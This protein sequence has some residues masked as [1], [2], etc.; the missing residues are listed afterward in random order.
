MLSLWRKQ[1]ERQHISTGEQIT[2]RSHIFSCHDD[3][4]ERL[5]T[6]RPR[7]HVLLW[8][9]RTHL[10][11]YT[12]WLVD[13][14]SHMHTN[15]SVTTSFSSVWASQRNGKNGSC[16]SFGICLSCFRYL[17]S[18]GNSLSVCCTAETAQ[19]KQSWPLFT[20]K[21]C[22]PHSTNICSVC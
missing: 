3:V 10:Q 13:S 4:N 11:L 8:L 16:C 12:L 21:K 6:R 17:C 22:I 14:H 20:A 5:K 2:E 19:Q 7:R 15:P 9:V 1:Q 18:E